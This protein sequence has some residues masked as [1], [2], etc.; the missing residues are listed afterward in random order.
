[1]TISVFGGLLWTLRDFHAKHPILALPVL[2]R[3]MSKTPH[4]GAVPKDGEGFVFEA[5]SPLFE[6]VLT[7][8]WGDEYL[9]RQAC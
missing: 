2:S 1:M 4:S 9:N 6:K 8:M 3:C 7:C 5:R